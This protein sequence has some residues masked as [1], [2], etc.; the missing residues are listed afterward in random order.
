MRAIIALLKK[1]KWVVFI[2]LEVICFFVLAFS[3]VFTN[4]TDKQTM[5]RVSELSFLCGFVFIPTI[6]MFF[7][8]E[9]DEKPIYKD[10]EW[11]D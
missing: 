6:S 9:K 4:A 2:V 10:K 8:I 3:L 1:P 7:L 11:F 5:D